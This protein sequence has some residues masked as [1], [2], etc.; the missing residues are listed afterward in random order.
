MV[1]VPAVVWR[2]GAVCRALTIGAVVGMC[3]GGLAWLDSGALLTGV[4]V[5][6]IVG[7]FYGVWMH[8]RMTRFWPGAR[9]LTGDERVVVAHTARRGERVPDERLAQA[10]T[11]YGRGLHAA[12][13]TARPFRWVV[14]FVLVVA[15]ATAVW[16]AA[17][18]S[19]GNAVVSA[20][21][22]V[23]LLVEVLWWPKRQQLILDN[24]DRA[25]M[26]AEPDEHV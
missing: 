15:V 1:T 16:D 17:I 26:S 23:A 22:L 14:P 21:Y 9:R 4:I 7:T 8:R 2:G 12:A 18:G 5:F 6:G 13:E 11:D 20:I 24:A 25:S 19:W 10:V 3:T